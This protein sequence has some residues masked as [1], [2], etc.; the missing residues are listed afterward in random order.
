MHLGKLF[1]AHGSAVCHNDGDPKNVEV[2][3]ELVA[4][5]IAAGE[6]SYYMCS[7]WS[8]TKPVWYTVYDLP[9]GPPMA[10]ATLDSNGVWTR[11]LAHV[12]VSYSTKD[13]TGTIS[14]SY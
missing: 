6:H 14:W 1:E 5:L 8:G 11:R 4:F 10:N 2:Q 9:I 7:G 12:N 13:E 3:T